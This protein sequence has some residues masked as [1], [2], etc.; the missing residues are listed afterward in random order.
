MDMA[1]DGNYRESRWF[2]SWQRRDSLETFHLPE[3]VTSVTGSSSILQS[4]ARRFA[5]PCFPV[6]YVME[7]RTYG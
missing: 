5:C 7:Y 1:D 2:T 4:I 3:L 6:D